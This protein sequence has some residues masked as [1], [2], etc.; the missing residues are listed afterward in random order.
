MAAVDEY[1]ASLTDEQRAA[2]QRVRDAV[3]AEVEDVDE[4]I[5]YGIPGFKYR[6]KYLLGY[7]A[8]TNHLSVFPGP[9]AV[10]AVRGEL[11][12]FKTSKGTIQFTLAPP[13]PE[14]VLRKLVALRVAAIDR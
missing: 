10:D 9:E 1:L 3:R 8:F 7:A 4:G 14:S 2:L 12:G 5:S 6:G 11:A 13:L